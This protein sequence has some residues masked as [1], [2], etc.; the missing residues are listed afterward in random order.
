MPPM[1]RELRPCS[2]DSGGTARKSDC[3]PCQ[4]HTRPSHPWLTRSCNK[5]VVVQ[6]HSVLDLAAEWSAAASP[7]LHEDEHVKGRS[8][9]AASRA[10]GAGSKAHGRWVAGTAPTKF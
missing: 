2:S 1:S 6:T 7:R 3:A 9:T 4:S 8:D 10:C 5:G